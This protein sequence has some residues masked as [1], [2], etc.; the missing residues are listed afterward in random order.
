MGQAKVVRDLIDLRETDHL[1][2][3]SSAPVESLEDINRT[4]RGIRF[5]HDGQQRDRLVCDFIAGCDRL[6][7]RQPAVYSRREEKSALREY[8]YGWFRGAGEAAPNPEIPRLC[9]HHR[10]ERRYVPRGPRQSARLYLQVEP[11]ENLDTWSDDISGRA[12]SA[13]AGR[14]K[15]PAEFAAQS[16]SATSPAYAFVCESMRYGRLCIAGDAAH[17]VPPSGAKGLKSRGRRRA[18]ASGGVASLP[19][20]ATRI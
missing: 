12:R 3:C 16:C 7:W 6:S 20:Q 13:H 5:V 8:P 4:G 2:C 11:E 17:I 9:A 19:D 15:Q 14:L 10:G 1:R 18:G